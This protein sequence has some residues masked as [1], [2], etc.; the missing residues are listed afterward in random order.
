VVI[1]TASVAALA[2]TQL[3]VAGSDASTLYSPLV[4]LFLIPG[5][6]DRMIVFYPILPW[7]SIAGFGMVFGRGLLSNERRAYAI[8]LL[9]GLVCLSLFLSD[10]LAGA[11]GDFHEVAPGWIG[12]L[13]TT[14]YPPSV[15]F[16]LMTLGLDLVL[17][18]LF[19]LGANRLGRL[20]QPLI[21]FG[22]S[23]LFFYILHLYLY[24]LMGFA[25]PQG[26]TMLTMYVIW[27]VG[28][29]VLYPECYWYGRFKQSRPIES[30]W[31]FF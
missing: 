18:T 15:A 10:R 2:A 22:R 12:L 24:G 5:H 26:A 30:I 27:L 17:L 25:F 14:K 4:R 11:L 3:L 16:V 31:R 8:G 7:F 21:V 23:A 13:N 6:T 20:T 28:L 29:V 19:A 1:V 9:V